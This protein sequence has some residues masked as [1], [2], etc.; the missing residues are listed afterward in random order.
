MGAQLAQ[1]G[2]GF[3]ALAFVGCMC[4]QCGPCEGRA[5]CNTGDMQESRSNNRVRVREQGSVTV[6][7][8]M[9]RQASFALKESLPMPVTKT[10]CEHHLI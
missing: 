5:F 9:Q 2:V 4:G 1:K 10:C 7:S 3:R 8:T 6:S